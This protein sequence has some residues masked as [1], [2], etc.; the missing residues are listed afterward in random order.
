MRPLALIPSLV[1]LATPAGCFASNGVLTSSVDVPVSQAPELARGTL[2]VGTRTEAL[3]K[4]WIAPV[5]QKGMVFLRQ[6]Q[7]PEVAVSRPEDLARVSPDDELE[8][9]VPLKGP[10]KTELRG[11]FLVLQSAT[12]VFIAPRSEIASLR[13]ITPS[14]AKT[15]VF[16]GLVLAP[17][18]VGIA[19]VLTAATVISVLLVSGIVEI[20]NKGSQGFVLYT[21]N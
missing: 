12:G 21:P 9:V 10:V 18:A 20:A 2:R 3:G 15:G 16:Y 17:G 7:R 11:D 5:P 19:G 6:P 1:L 4:Y 13:V 8:R 14:R